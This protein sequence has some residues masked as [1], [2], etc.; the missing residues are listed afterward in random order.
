MSTTYQGYTFKGT[1]RYETRRRIGQLKFICHFEHRR[2]GA[3]D[4]FKG[5]GGNSQVDGK[6]QTCGE[7][8]CRATQ[9]QWGT[10]GS[11]TNRLCQISP[12]RPHLV[13]VTMLRQ[14]SLSLSRLFYSEFLQAGKGQGQMFLLSLLF[15]NYQLKTNI[16]KGTWWDGQTRVLLSIIRGR[17]EIFK[18]TDPPEQ[19]FLSVL[20]SEVLQ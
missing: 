5:K 8:S 14:C 7:K 15:L 1:I 6:E 16:P 13:Y 19:L 9:Q 12:C 4:C 17:A 18:C 3:E 2:R 10:Q 20:Y 11:L